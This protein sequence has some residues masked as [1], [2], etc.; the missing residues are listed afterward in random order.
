MATYNYK[1]WDNKGNLKE[2]LRQGSC[3]E[4]VLSWLRDQSLIPVEVGLPQQVE[5]EEFQLSRYMKVKS[6][7]MSSFCWQLGIMLDGGIPITSALQTISDDS[8]NRYFGNVLKDIMERIHRGETLTDSIRRHPKVFNTLCVAIISA[9]E[10]GGC[11]V[12]TLQRLAVYYENRDA[13]ARKVKGALSYP[14]FALCFIMFIVSV[15]MIFIIPKF[16]MIFEQMG[17]ELPALTQGLMDFY[18]FMKGNIFYI[19]MFIGLMITGLIIFSKTRYG[20]RKVSS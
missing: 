1:A 18:A 16:Q 15:M 10:S 19:F 6:V 4:E 5:E 12:L 17:H 9:G 7:E 3:E 11:L 13:L 8:S 14:I 2:G 20:H